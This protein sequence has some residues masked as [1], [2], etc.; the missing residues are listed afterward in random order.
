MFPQVVRR[1][2]RGY[3]SRSAH[4]GPL[5]LTQVLREAWRPAPGSVELSERELT[6]VTP[7]LLESGTGPL[8]WWKLRSSV[9]RESEVVHDLQLS[10]RQA[11]IE[12]LLR[13]R[14]IDEAFR[15]LRSAGIEPILFKG[16]A[17]ARL[18]PEVGLRPL[19]DID[20]YVP[21]ESLGTAQRVVAE[22]PGRKHNID[23]QHE[24]V[25]ILQH[26][27]HS[28]YARS[29]LLKLGKTDIR[30]M[31]P[32]D[33]LASLCMHFLKHGGWRPLWL[34]DIAVALESRSASFD[35]ELCLGPDPRKADWIA[36]TLGV[37]HILLGADV[38]D[39]PADERAQRLPH[40]LV[41]TVLRAW[42]HPRLDEH[43]VPNLITSSLRHPMSLPRALRARWLNPVEATVRLGG[44]FNELPR[45]PYQLANYALQLRRFAARWEQVVRSPSDGPK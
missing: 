44:A 21:T 5:L 45:L 14:E 40:W 38:A 36:C 30:V 23:F 26:S 35:W 19:G 13:E 18:Y 1:H 29:K 31:G 3:A 24:E 34:C 8:G 9:W 42:E 27:W 12:V 37:A 17:V 10:Y 41:P 2:S 15:V 4:A 39:T 22:P 16:W 11:A 32:E 7:L 43:T 28:V 6:E 25:D 33:N 20:L